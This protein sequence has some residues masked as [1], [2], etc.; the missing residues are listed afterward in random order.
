MLPRYTIF[1][2]LDNRWIENWV[3]E[4]IN[5]HSGLMSIEVTWNRDDVNPGTPFITEYDRSS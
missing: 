2:A 1:S 3:T 5:P 4:F